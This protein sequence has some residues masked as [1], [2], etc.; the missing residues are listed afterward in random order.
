M[1]H[2]I[3]VNIEAEQVTIVFHPLDTAA[4]S[5][6]CPYFEHDQRAGYVLPLPTLKRKAFRI[7]R[8]FFGSSGK[9]AQWTRTW[10]GPW[11][12][13]NAE[14]MQRLPGLFDTHEEA[15]NAEIE[16]ILSK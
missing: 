11:I 10:K 1:T 15:V 16:W 8:A 5:S 9:V 2:P 6:I 7:L 4:V 3:V 14:T 12:L 13:L